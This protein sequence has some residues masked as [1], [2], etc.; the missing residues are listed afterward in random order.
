MKTHQS[1]FTLIEVMSALAIVAAAFAIIMGFEM[2]LMTSTKRS[3]GRVQRSWAMTNYLYEC[4]GKS[5]E[6][7]EKDPNKKL[8]KKLEQPDL[9]LTYQ[10]K[11]ITEGSDLDDLE[12]LIIETVQAEWKNKQGTTNKDQIISIVFAMEKKQEQEKEQSQ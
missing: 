12:N 7:L 3:S 4:H 6:E 11:P 1:G 5:L 2:N 10:R 9:T 8:T